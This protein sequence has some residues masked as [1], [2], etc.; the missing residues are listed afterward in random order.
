MQLFLMKILSK[1]LKNAQ[2]QDGT[3]NNMISLSSNEEMFTKPNYLKE[4]EINTRILDT[5]LSIW[6]QN[7]TNHKTTQPYVTYTY[8]TAIVLGNHNLKKISLYCTEQ[9]VKGNTPV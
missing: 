9:L 3:I 5:I 4:T 6:P 1:H 7:A 8:Y 2:G